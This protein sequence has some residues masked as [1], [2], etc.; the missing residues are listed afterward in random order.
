MQSII[1]LS[2]IGI[3]AVLFIIQVSI[4]I[5]Y[6]LKCKENNVNISLL[7]IVFMIMRKAKPSIIINNLIKLK[8]NNIDINPN[9]LEAH[10]LAKGN[11]DK[12]TEGLILV[13]KKGIN[14]NYLRLAALDLAGQDVIE[15]INKS[16]GNELYN[17][18]K[19]A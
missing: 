7:N 12:I 2:I 3:I 9:S 1:F 16:K 8:L 11:V 14:A 13:N 5:Y 19:T 18:Y 10:Y 6:W 4:P 17:P 15:C